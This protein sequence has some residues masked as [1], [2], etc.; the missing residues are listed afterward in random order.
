MASGPTSS[1][2]TDGQTME[3]VIDC[4]F[5][6]S[7]VT[8]HGDCNREIKR[9]LLLGRNVM[10]HLLKRHMTWHIKKQRYHFAKKGL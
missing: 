2:Q 3:T 9:H 1:W 5:L 7:K 6:D 10:T 8:A 4:L